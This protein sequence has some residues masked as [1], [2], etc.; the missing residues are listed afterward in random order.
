MNSRRV[1]VVDDDADIRDVLREVLSAE[2]YEV[3]L[4]ADA[5]QA[6]LAFARR[7]PDLVLLDIWMPGTDGIS[8]LRE[9]S[10]L[11][12][13]APCPVVMLSGH[14][15][16]RTAAEATRL[17]AFDFLE[18]PPSL[19]QLLRTV[20]RALTHS[21]KAPRTRVPLLPPIAPLGRSRVIRRLR[22]EVE[23][24]APHEV[25][26]LLTGEIGTGREAFARHIHALSL[27][28][29]CPFVAVAA[30]SLT[31]DAASALHGIRNAALEPG[32]YEQANNGTLFI[33]GLEDLSEG[34]QR[35]LLADIKTGRYSPVG[36]IQSRALNVRFLSSSLPGLEVCGVPPFR[37]DLL[38]H[39]NVVTLRVPPLREYAE[40]VP[41][42]LS[43][44]V[45]R[46]ADEAGLPFRR[47][48]VAAQNRLRNYHWPGNLHELQN[49]I[50][51][52]LVS[53]DRAEITLDEVEH[54]LSEPIAIPQARLKEDLLA[55]P[56]REARQQFERAFLQQQLLICNG[57]VNHLAKRVG[58]EITR[59][60]SKVHSLGLALPLREAREQFERAYL[61]Q[62]LLI[63]NGKIEQVAKRVG[64]ERTHVYRKLHSLGVEFRHMTAGKSSRSPPPV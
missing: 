6:R 18:K 50:Q 63:C 28:K 4:A 59:A 8:L 48:T 57:K 29:D 51:R 22:E 21:T 38:S 36:D 10:H 49:L 40:D 58:M 31:E 44:Y 20:R 53:S 34:T 39:L 56:L 24:I 2:G 47:F 42:L 25:P 60:Y 11:P 13:E 61:Q 33:N 32:R 46:L 7:Y 5:A 15:T 17:G 55:L 23:R 37:A 19:A 14:G 16:I 52:L 43:S 64:M 35:L 12:S 26:V 45:D 41:E 27:R 62:Q 54:E 30:G 9:W 1:L 3:D